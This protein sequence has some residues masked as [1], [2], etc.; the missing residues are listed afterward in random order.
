[1]KNNQDAEETSFDLGINKV[2]TMK[3]Y[4]ISESVISVNTFYGLEYSENLINLLS[5]GQ[6]D[7]YR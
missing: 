6:Q 1:M 2:D 5:K 4:D 3:H 7:K